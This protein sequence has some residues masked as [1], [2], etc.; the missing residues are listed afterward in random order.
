MKTHIVTLML[1]L[2]VSSVTAA[3]VP[4]QTTY[5]GKL[6]DATGAPEQ[7]IHTIGF[8][9][10][11]NATGGTALWSDSLTVAVVDG[12]YS[13]DL[14]T[15]SGDPLPS[16]LFDGTVRYLELNVDGDTLAPRQ[17]IGSVAYAI[18]AGSVDG[19][20]NATSISVNGSQIVDTNG[21]WTG[22]VAG[23]QGPT[24]D[25]GPQGP[26]GPTGDTGPAGPTGATGP[27]GPTGNTGPGPVVATDGGL[28]GDGST[29][30]PLRLAASYRGQLD[31]QANAQT[32]FIEAE[33][34]AQ[35]LSNL[36]SG[37][38][39]TLDPTASG[40]YYFQVSLS[41]NTNTVVWSMDNSNLVNLSI[42]KWGQTR[43][44][45]S[46]RIQLGSQTGTTS[47]ANFQCIAVRGGTTVVLDSVAIIPSQ[48][49]TTWSN[50][51]LLCDWLPDDQDT[52]VQ[53]NGFQ[54]HQTNLEIDYVTAQPDPSS[55]CATG[56]SP[57]NKG[58]LCVE[59]AIDPAAAYLTAETKCEA[60]PGKGLHG[61]VCTLKDAVDACGAFVAGDL[62][63]D[64]FGGVGPTGLG[65]YGEEVD[66]THALSW[67]TGSC[68]LGSLVAATPTVISSNYPYRCC[69]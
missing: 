13:V 15:T 5:Q 19:T 8:S 29:T 2:L 14:G 36:T 4:Q 32:I 7:G 38:P 64:F 28:T 55:P 66:N 3:Q 45:V 23:L 47:I 44:R 1:G 46:A 43:T 22:S 48:Y 57:V 31:A 60:K 59:T 27:T 12:L 41:G 34:P 50:L 69:Y 65:W 54:L 30:N 62:S 16:D 42:P 35:T 52:E 33:T 11:A 17:A 21:N 26:Q 25:T 51:S 58:R 39:K 53:F 6:L 20:V 9:V 56:F 61:H 18:R 10:F 49:P 24:G 67:G 40:G 37:S 63:F 68:G